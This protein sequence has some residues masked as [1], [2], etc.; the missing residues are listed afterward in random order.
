MFFIQA[1]QKLQTE[2]AMR[3]AG[4]VAPFYW[5]DAPESCGVAVVASARQSCTSAKRPARSCKERGDSGERPTVREGAL[6]YVRLE[7]GLS[8]HPP[9]RS[10]FCYISRVQRER[11]DKILVDRGLAESRTKAQALVM[12]ASVLRDEQLVSKALRKI[13]S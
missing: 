7:F 1:I 12:S 6:F 13:F 5:V 11:I 9:S 2:A 3:M 4:K 10:G 8:R